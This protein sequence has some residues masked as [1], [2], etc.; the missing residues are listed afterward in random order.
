MQDDL[1]STLTTLLIPLGAFSA[2]EYESSVGEPW[3]LYF[4]GQRLSYLSPEFFRTFEGYFL[5]ELPYEQMP[6]DELLD[7]YLVIK[8]MEKYRQEQRAEAFWTALGLGQPREGTDDGEIQ[9][10]QEL[11]EE[12]GEDGDFFS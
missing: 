5:Q 11:Q 6:V 12:L 10:N 2:I 8:K 9:P 1:A 4:R 7:V 3:D